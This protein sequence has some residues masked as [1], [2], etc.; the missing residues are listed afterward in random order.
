MQRSVFWLLYVVLDDQNDL[1]TRD[2]LVNNDGIEAMLDTICTFKDDERLQEFSSACFR[3]LP[4]EQNGVY[5]DKMIALRVPEA[6]MRTMRNHKSHD[7]ITAQCCMALDAI[8]GHSTKHSQC[9]RLRRLMIP[10]MLDSLTTHSANVR[11]VDHAA[12]LLNTP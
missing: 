2:I 11:L 1:R 7:H 3:R 9:G 8:N 12:Y 6:L 10:A 5:E 4:S